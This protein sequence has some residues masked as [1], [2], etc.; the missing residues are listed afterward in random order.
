MKKFSVSDGTWEPMTVKR[1][2]M[3]TERRLS[4]TPTYFTRI[5]PIW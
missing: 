4:N 2:G 3:L 1:I 5:L